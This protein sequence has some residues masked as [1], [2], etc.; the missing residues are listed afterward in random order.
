[1]RQKGA[2][3]TDGQV[4]FSPPSPPRSGGE[5]PGEVAFGEQGGESSVSGTFQSSVFTDYHPGDSP[6]STRV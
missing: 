4:K 1:M 2:M 6:P 5:G 3:L